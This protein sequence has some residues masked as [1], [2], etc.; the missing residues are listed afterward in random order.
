[1]WFLPWCLPLHRGVTA[2]EV[3]QKNAVAKD[4]DSLLQKIDKTFLLTKEIPENFRAALFTVNHNESFKA[5]FLALTQGMKVLRLK[6]TVQ[7]DGIE[8][9]R[10]SF[11]VYPGPGKNSGK[12]I[13]LNS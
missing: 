5:A 11:V 2:V 3:N 4:F 13:C 12:K 8:F 1:M 7:V 6:K 9:P 10:G